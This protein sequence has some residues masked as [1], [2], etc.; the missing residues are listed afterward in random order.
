MG[1]SRKIGSEDLRKKYIII[2]NFS[3]HQP[4]RGNTALN[5]GAVS[6]LK[7][8][9]LMNDDH[10]IISFVFYKNPFKK[11]YRKEVHENN[12]ID[13][14]PCKSHIIPVFYLQQRLCVKWGIVLP[15][16]KFGRLIR[17][18]AYEA[19]DYGGDGFSDIYGDGALN[20]RYSQTVVLKKLGIPLL[21]LPQTIGPFQ[22]QYNYDYAKGLLEYADSVYVRDEKFVD[23]L[24][25]LNIPYTKTKDLSAFMKP[26]PWD[27]D[28]KPNA[29]G[30][31]VSG[32]AYSNKF[33]GLVGEFDS[34]PRLISEIIAHFRSAGHPIYLIPHSY[35][36][37]LPDENNDDIVA[38]REV[39]QNLEDKTDVYLIDRDLV[40][41]QIKYVISKMTFFIGTRMHANFAAI[42]TNTP[43]FGLAYSYKFEGAF[44]NNGLGAD[45]TYMINNLQ[46]S[47]IP[48]V[49]NMIDKIYSKYCK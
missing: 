35:N 49:L 48:D 7:E 34:Y 39:Y 45:Q 5:I 3:I 28:V 19:A 10:E 24:N 23:E 17:N 18:V 40:S 9:G 31:N 41:P 1:K 21:I 30:I 8:K 37:A 15:F 13:G 11:Q 6:F 20:A 16:T 33:K 38:C 4:N 26:L 12:E 22:R 14:K 27:I 36:Y 43:V 25:K 42:Y 32:L 44:V 2:K 47:E 46:E 29:I